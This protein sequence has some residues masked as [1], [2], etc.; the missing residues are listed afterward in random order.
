MSKAETVDRMN[1]VLFKTE[2][3]TASEKR[4][5]KKM[6]TGY[7]NFKKTALEAGIHVET[8]RGVI[9]RGYGAP[10]TVAKIRSL[11]PSDAAR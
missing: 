10:D 1:K 7:T 6:V 3:L 9:N 8:L 11:F 2:E 5:L 4:K